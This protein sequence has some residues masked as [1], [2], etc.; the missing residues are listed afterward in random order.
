MKM[1]INHPCV[2]VAHTLHLQRYRG[3]MITDKCLGKLFTYL[4]TYITYGGKFEVKVTGDY[5]TRFDQA[6]LTLHIDHEN[7]IKTGIEKSD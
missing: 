1:V 6:G 3:K 4:E 7:Y 5:K 2:F